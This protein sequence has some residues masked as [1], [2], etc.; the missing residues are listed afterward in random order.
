MMPR[1]NKIFFPCSVLLCFLAVYDLPSS[2]TLQGRRFWANNPTKEKQR[3]T[4][5]RSERKRLIVK[6]GIMC[7]SRVHILM[8]RMILDKFVFNVFKSCVPLR[9]LVLS[10]SFF[11]NERREVWAI[12]EWSTTRHLCSKQNNLQISFLFHPT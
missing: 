9:P 6:H 7:L 10:Q 11:S 8:L 5:K 12:W 4:E 1:W 2:Y 3:V